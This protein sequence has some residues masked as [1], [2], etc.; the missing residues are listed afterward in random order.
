[1]AYSISFVGV[2][3][4]FHSHRAYFRLQFSSSA[5]SFHRK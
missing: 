3:K 1:M 5:S 4:Y 2:K